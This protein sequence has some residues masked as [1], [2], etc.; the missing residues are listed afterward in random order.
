MRPA[1]YVRVSSA[2]QVERYSLPS[3]ERLTADYCGYQGWPAPA[4]YREEGH[5]AFLDDPY[6]RPVFGRLLADARA[7]RFDTLVVIDL[8]RF[9]RNTLA[10][11]LAKRDLEDCGCRIVS[12][13]QQIDFATPDGKLMFVVNSGVAEYASHQLSRKVRAGLDQKRRKGLHVGGVPYGAR[14]VDGRLEPD[15]IRAPWLRRILELRPTHGPSRIAG[16][17]NEAGAPSA[18]GGRFEARTI[19]AIVERSAWL[20]DQPA[21]WPALYRRAAAVP[22]QPKV[23][24][25]RQI[26][27]LSGLLR[28]PCGGRLTHN[29]RPEPHRTVVCYSRRLRPRGYGCAIPQ[30]YARVYEEQVTA[31]LLALPDLADARPV[32]RDVRGERA[33]L[34]ERRRRLARTYRDGLIDDPDYEREKAAL[35]RLDATLPRVAGGYET[36]RDLVAV[37][38]REW[39][40]LTPA[41][42]NTVLRHLLAG[43]LV[44]RG[45]AEPQPLPIFADLLAAAR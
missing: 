34:A 45:R 10:A 8:D 20:L 39:A 41:A 31:W 40:G 30:T 3:Q 27:M 25:D 43:V 28:C 5:T 1:A 37:A 26:H 4:V 32:E 22:V 36:I 19:Y 18:K 7:R 17:L 14:R 29:G 35:D 2:G 6:A 23:R 11:L 12:L 16:M 9:A 15:P 44:A 33:D 42:Q 21:P 38:R 24:R 13:N